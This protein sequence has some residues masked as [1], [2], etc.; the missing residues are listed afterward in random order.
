MHEA[1][2]PSPSAVPRDSTPCVNTQE[3]EVF[4]YFFF[5][6]QGGTATRRHIKLLNDENL[7]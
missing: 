4:S 6:H 7:L 1:S 2:G 5:E 3:T